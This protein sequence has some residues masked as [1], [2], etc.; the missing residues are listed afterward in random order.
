[1]AKRYTVYV[2]D[3]FHYMDE[4]ERYKHGE[5]DDCQSAVAACKQ[6]VDE[7]LSQCDSRSG[8]DEM[9]KQYTTFGEDPWVSSD[10]PDC[11]FSAWGYAKER[12]RE[13]AQG[14]DLRS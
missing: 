13:L 11:K 5:F 3:N 2:D 7:S 12:C 10:D 8:A 6:I 4:S 9:F 1:M 14:P